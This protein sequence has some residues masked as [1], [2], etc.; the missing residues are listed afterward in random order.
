MTVNLKRRL[1]GG[2]ALLVIAL[3][4]FPLVFNGAGYQERQLN[5]VIPPI[6]VVPQVVQIE[7][8]N[9]IIIESEIP[10]PPAEAVIVPAPAVEIAEPL[11]QLAPTLNPVED[12]PVLDAD[13]VPAAWTLQL[14]SFKQEENA[15]ALRNRLIEAGYKVY[16]RQGSDVVRVYVGPDMQRSRLE[17]LQAQLKQEYGLDGIIVRFTTQ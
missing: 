11:E 12:P 14:A 8:Q 2:A 15:R 17:T 13:Q 4:F 9:P 10:A 5:P 3:V 7:P 1:I 6:P 16:I